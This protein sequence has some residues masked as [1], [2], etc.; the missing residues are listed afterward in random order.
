MN[1][2]LIVTLLLLCCC[3]L[4]YSESF[5]NAYTVIT[6][7]QPTQSADKI[8]VLEI[9]WYGC[10][11][12]YAFEPYL[13]QWLANKSATVE[14]RQVPGILG[15]NWV[16]HAKAYYVAE[17]LGILDKVHQPLFDAIHKD[18]RNIYTDDDIR[19]FFIGLGVDEAR[20]SEIYNSQE[21]LNK[22]RQAYELQQKYRI[23]GVPTV[24]ING[25]YLTSPS[26]AGSHEQTLKVMDYLVDKELAESPKP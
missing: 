1:K 9:F 2:S 26:M 21:L 16:P 3:S 23:T 4:V 14:F 18:K 5:E 25:K 6:P 12:C 11:H 22:L 8:E 15:N 13:R 24:I 10:P 17:A 19:A 7:A 20:F